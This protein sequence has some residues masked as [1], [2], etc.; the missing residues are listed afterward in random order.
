MKI[1]VGSD[2]EA[3][4]I[5]QFIL[6]I[7]ELGIIDFMEKQ[8][9]ECNKFPKEQY[10]NTDDYRALEEAISG[11]Q[12]SIEVDLSEEG[13]YYEEDDF[14]VGTCSVCKGE[15]SG[16]M[17]GLDRLTYDD[18]QHMMSPEGM[19]GWKCEDCFGKDR[20]LNG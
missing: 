1:I 7:H 8:D 3:K 6:G 12:I 15:T 14:V 19:K 2:N 4:L 10:L 13:I 20:D 17:D 11:E 18:Y 9:G 16:R 5:R